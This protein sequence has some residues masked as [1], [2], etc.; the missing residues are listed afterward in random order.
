[1]DNISPA[2]VAWA[3]PVFSI[4]IFSLINWR[5]LSLGGRFAGPF[6]LYA[7]S[8]GTGIAADIYLGFANSQSAW[9]AG[10]WAP[11]FYTLVFSLILRFAPPGF[12]RPLRKSNREFDDPNN[13]FLDDHIDTDE[14]EEDDL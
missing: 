12:L 13:D 2:L 5:E 11:L 8:L 14:L 6:I 4:A 9:I 7:F 1:M 10:V 3:F